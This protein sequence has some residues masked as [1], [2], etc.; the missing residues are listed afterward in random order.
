MYILTT[1]I[2]ITYKICKAYY[3]FLGSGDPW[4]SSNA[5]LFT[6]RPNATLTRSPGTGVPPCDDGTSTAPDDMREKPAFG[7]G[8]ADADAPGLAPFE[9]K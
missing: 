7:A 4:T 2:N 6:P 3:R 8:D 5:F 1:H 9:V